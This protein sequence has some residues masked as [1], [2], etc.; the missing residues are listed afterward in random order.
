MPDNIP[1]GS[2]C[3]G[4]LE[5]CKNADRIC[6]PGLRRKS[7]LNQLP[8]LGGANGA[9]K[10]AQSTPPAPPSPGVF[11]IRSLLAPLETPGIDREKEHWRSKKNRAPWESSLPTNF[12]YHSNHVTPGHTLEYVNQ[13]VPAPRKKPEDF[14]VSTKHKRRHSF[15]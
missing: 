6:P 14:K 4:L 15:Q 13:G 9:Q 2:E 10:P 3:D 1:R 11:P 5:N 12:E 8:D 7:A